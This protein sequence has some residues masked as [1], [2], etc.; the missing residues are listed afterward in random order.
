MFYK[1]TNVE[2]FQINKFDLW[3]NYFQNTQFSDAIFQKLQ[4]IS[5]FITIAQLRSK[6]IDLN[7]GYYEKISFGY[8]PN[9]HYYILDKYVNQNIYFECDL[10]ITKKTCKFLTLFC[11]LK[12]YSATNFY[13]ICDIS[14]LWTFMELQ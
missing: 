12:K 11:H 4:T 14:S 13:I 9:A 2:V 10:C 6:I 8:F 3:T 1:L 5:W 7:K